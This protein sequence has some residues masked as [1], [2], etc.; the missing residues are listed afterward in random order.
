MVRTDSTAAQRRQLHCLSVRNR[1]VAVVVHGPSLVA[2]APTATAVVPSSPPCCSSP[3]RPCALGQPPSG[4]FSSQLKIS[5]GR[6]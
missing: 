2:P 6:E 3:S 5:I 4:S 1:T